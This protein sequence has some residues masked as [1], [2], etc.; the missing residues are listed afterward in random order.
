MVC[1]FWYAV[2][3]SLGLVFNGDARF[4]KVKADMAGS[5]GGE[6][7][8]E[9]WKTDHPFQ[10]FS[11]MNLRTLQSILMAICKDPEVNRSGVVAQRCSVLKPP[12][13]S[14]LTKVHS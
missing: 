7:R 9:Q 13:Y 11:D 4:I 3:W 5:H 1:A 14:Q 8:P 12:R 10:D 6:R 2:P